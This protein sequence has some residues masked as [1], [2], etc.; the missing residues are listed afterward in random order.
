MATRGF[1]FAY[2]LDGSTKVPVI[3]DFPVHGTGAYG[4]GDL[5]KVNGSADGEVAR[6]T[7]TTTEVTGVMQ[8]ARASGSDADKMKVAIITRNQVWRCST[9]AASGTSIIGVRKTLDTTDH[10]TI[11]DTSTEIG[12]MILVDNTAVDDDG[13]LIYHV[14]FADST[15]GNT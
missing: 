13:Y 15:F 6:V 14:V 8:E 7:T 1:E 9:T 3:R 12:A 11:D 10:N 2:N 5:V 4:I